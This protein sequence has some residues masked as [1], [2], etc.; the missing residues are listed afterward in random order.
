MN[1]SSILSQGVLSLPPASGI[2]LGHF[3]N[4]CQSVRRARHNGSP[5]RKPGVSI[6]RIRA[7]AGRHK[8]LS[9]HHN[10]K[11]CAPL[12]AVVNTPNPCLPERR[13]N[14]ITRLKMGAESKL[15]RLAGVGARRRNPERSRGSSSDPEDFYHASSASGSSTNALSQKP[16]IES[17]FSRCASFSRSSREDGPDSEYG[18][19]NDVSAVGAKEPSPGAEARGKHKKRIEP[20]RGGTSIYRFTTTKESVTLC[21]TL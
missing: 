17:G 3:Q 4:Q 12:P 18:S 5:G 6:K 8:H 9:F 20:R 11:I 2:N 13:S 7:P 16:H 1:P 21:L 14:P 19:R 10:K 15:S